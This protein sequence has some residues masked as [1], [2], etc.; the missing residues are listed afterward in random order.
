MNTLK[1]SINSDFLTDAQQE[2]YERVEMYREEGHPRIN[3]HG[4][5]A[6][7]KT[8]LCWVLA[9]SAIWSYYPVMP[10]RARSP[11]VIYD[12]G[13]IER[14][15]QRQFRNNI[16]INSISNAVYVTEKPA[17]EIHPQVGLNPGEDHYEQ[18]AQVWNELGLDPDNAPSY[19][20]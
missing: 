6:A 19:Q 18:I 8:Y 9:A 11:H 10:G 3:L 13:T 7:G 17:D 5:R 14:M 4:P 20:E 2:A 12:H 1:E 16:Q 15:S